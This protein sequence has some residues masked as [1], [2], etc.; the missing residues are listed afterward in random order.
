VEVQGEEVTPI[1]TR[2]VIHIPSVHV[3]LRNAR[4]TELL[5]L[6]QLFAANP[7]AARL[8][9]H[10]EQNGK[11][12]QVLSGLRVDVNPT[13]LQEVGAVAGRVG[14]SVWVE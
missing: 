14:G 6:R 5:V 11:E 12:D 7:G 13:L 3:R 9:F 8:L 10:I 2:Q 1:E 4:R